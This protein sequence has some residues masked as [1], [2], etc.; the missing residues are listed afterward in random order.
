MKYIEALRLIDISVKSGVIKELE[1]KIFV[2]REG[3][4]YSR[5]GWYLDEKDTVAKELMKNKQGKEILVDELLLN[6]REKL[7]PT[8]YLWLLEYQRLNRD[9]ME[10]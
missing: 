4:P 6:N 9:I 10:G 3:T 1:G 5:E 8:D 2:Y 7:E